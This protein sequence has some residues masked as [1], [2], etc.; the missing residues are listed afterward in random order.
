MSSSKT[1]NRVDLL[2]KAHMLFAA[3]TGT[4]AVVLPN[5]FDWFMVHHEPGEALTLRK[6]VDEHS[7]IEHLIIR[8]YGSLILGQAW[9]TR[10]VSASRDAHLRRGVIQAYLLTFALTTLA[11]LRAQLTEPAVGART[12]T[13]WN[14][15][16]ILMFFSLSLGY[17]WF[18]FFEKI[19]VF[20][21]ITGNI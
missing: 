10:N 20:K 3:V 21:G 9:I 19:Q 6:N 7:K 17:G 4:I 5:V 11:L 15:L 8:M 12:F 16:N 1:D 13:S 14:W 2:F 18:A